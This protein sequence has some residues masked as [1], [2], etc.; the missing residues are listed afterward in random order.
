MILSKKTAF[1]FLVIVLAGGYIYLK[2]PPEGPAYDFITAKKS[3]IFQTVSVTG[4]VKPTEIIDLAFEKN[5]KIAL[6][7]KKVGEAIKK[8][9][10][11]AR[12][13][14]EELSTQLLQSQ[15]NLEAEEAGLNELKKGTRPE[16][17]KSTET[18]VANAEM[19]LKN[20][21]INLEQTKNKADADLK[22]AYNGASAAIQKS[23]SVAKTSLITLTDIQYLH[24]NG[25]T[26]EDINL[27]NAKASAV[28]S[29]LGAQ[30]AGR[31]TSESI[32]NLSGG[33]FASVQSA[34]N[35]PTNENIDKAIS[36]TIDA[37][38]KVKIALDAVPIATDLTAAEKTN[39]STE[40][41]NINT[42]IITISGKQQAI[43][44]QRTV[45]SNN[46]SSAQS[47]VDSAK[48]A[49]SL[50]K[51][52]LALKKA[53]NV[54][55]QISAKE[56][57]VKAAKA[58]VENIQAQLG[59]TI[60]RSPING[61]VTKQEANVG[62]IA[63]ANA[64]IVSIISEDKFKIETNIPETDI[65]KVK[66]G[67]MAKVTLDAYGNDVIF[68]AKVVSIDPAETIVEGVPTYK[69]TLQFTKEDS[70]IK[71]GM[72]AN[73]EISTDSREKV[74]VI[75][76]RAVI[77]KNGDKIVKILTDENVAKEINVK[78]GLRDSSGYIEVIEGLKEGEKVIISNK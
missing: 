48:N 50:A 51:D 67:D 4:S 3:N 21:E 72:T 47:S 39:I 27:E 15:A 23:V 41:S 28:Y 62:E 43:L 49:L 61:I 16:E 17:I 63:N 24:F 32:N 58:A 20:A 37:L 9:E 44:V 68:E 1:V 42:E 5:G 53:G 11:I 14:N 55:E 38:Q 60:L 12:L 64:I 40:K 19:S 57:K 26:Q 6:S 65:A 66:I 7:D 35:Y 46:I 73:V 74:I 69:T 25:K 22:N 8:D 77:V 54:A 10:I 2:R 76:Q 59:K 34:T 75:P 36:D 33:A 56:A 70:L 71:S 78:L 45:N 13:D 18:K 31:W 29:L 30:N 52:E